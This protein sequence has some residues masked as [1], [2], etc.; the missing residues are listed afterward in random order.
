MEDIAL[1]RSGKCVARV[2]MCQVGLWLT[3]E[4]ARAWGFEDHTQKDELISRVE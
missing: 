3:A 1:V 4:A 2:G